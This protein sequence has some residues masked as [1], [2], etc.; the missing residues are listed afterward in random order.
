MDNNV[1][2]FFTGMT[3]G[4]IAVV[5]AMAFSGDLAAINLG[6]NTNKVI[7]ECEKNIP[8]NQTCEIFAKVKE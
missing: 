4:C 3:L 1:G 7:V 5:I 8:R 2:F 6:K